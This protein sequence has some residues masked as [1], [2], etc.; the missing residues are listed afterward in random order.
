MPVVNYNKPRF[1][2]ETATEGVIAIG[3]RY[4]TVYNSG[5][6]TGSFGENGQTLSEIPAG[7]SLTFPFIPGMEYPKMEFSATT[8]TL[9]ITY[10][11]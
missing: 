7:A 8:T 5:A 10:I 9:L 4:I 11:I 6:A 1:R 2:K 3:M